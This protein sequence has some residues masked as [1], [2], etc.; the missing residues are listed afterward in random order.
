MNRDNLEKLAAYLEAIP[1]DYEHFSMRSY[2]EVEGA[3]IYMIDLSA[4]L[5]LR[6]G[7]VAC[8]VGHGPAA[9]IASLTDE[10][11]DDYSDRVFDLD[12]VEWAWCFSSDWTRVDDTPQGAAK[13]IRYMLEHGVPENATSQKK[14]QVPYMFAPGESA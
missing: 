10:N 14:G 3:H 8:A 2:L 7:T 1:A 4:E 13:R 6:C 9:G 5:L 11:W 12:L